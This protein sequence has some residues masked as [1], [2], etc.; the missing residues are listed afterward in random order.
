MIILLTA[1]LYGDWLG[2]P[3]WK[4]VFAI[5]IIYCVLHH[6]ISGA[7]AAGIRDAAKEA[8]EEDKK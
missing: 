5:L 6:L 8:K 1:T 3:I 2:L 4:Q 7:V